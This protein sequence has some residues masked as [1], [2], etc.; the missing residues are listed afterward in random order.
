MCGGFFGFSHLL[1]PSNSLTLRPS[2]ATE[3][4][5]PLQASW[6][7]AAADRDEAVAAVLLVDAHGVHDVVVLGVGLDLVVDDDLEP[8]VLHRLGDLVHDV[9][10]AQARGHHQRLLE[11]ELERLRAD[12]LVAPGAH[13]G[14]RERVELLDRE[15]LEQLVDLHGWPF[16]A[17]RVQTDRHRTL[18]PP[19]SHARKDRRG[20][21]ANPPIGAGAAARRSLSDRRRRETGRPGPGGRGRRTAPRRR[22]PCRRRGGRA[23]RAGRRACRARTGRRG[24]RG[25]PRAGAGRCGPRR[26]RR[27]GAAP[28]RG[29]TGGRSRR[30]GWRGCRGPGRRPSRGR[31][32]CSSGAVTR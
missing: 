2:C 6:R 20:G 5:A 23:C 13:Q 8:V 19:L 21:G 22:A 31:D 24:R 32:R 15:R 17:D 3:T 26:A 30:R 27:R 11:A 14:P 29:W 18:E 1:K 9:G 28:G 7:R 12:H 10:A 16:L 25:R 4:R